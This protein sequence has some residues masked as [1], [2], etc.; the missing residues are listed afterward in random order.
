MAENLNKNNTIN[1][2]NEL[3]DEYR[4]LAK[5]WGN[6]GTDILDYVRLYCDLIDTCGLIAFGKSVIEKEE[7]KSIDK[8]FYKYLYSDFEM[9]TDKYTGFYLGLIT[10][11]EDKAMFYAVE[12]AKA[13]KKLGWHLGAK[14]PLIKKLIKS[15]ARRECY[16]SYLKRHF[17]KHL[18]LSPQELESHYKYRVKLKRMRKKRKKY[19]ERRAKMKK[20]QK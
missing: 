20:T 15:K 18:T 16:K 13:C 7:Q 8:A 17:K 5:F 12:L 10:E 6:I 4:E 3:S 2:S 11:S 1:E 14:K 9:D 19:E